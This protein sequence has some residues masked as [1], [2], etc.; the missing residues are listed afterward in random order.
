[1]AKANA[2]AVLE[3]RN[4]ATANDLRVTL[5]GLQLSQTAD[6]PFDFSHFVEAGFGLSLF[7]DN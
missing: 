7:P 2:L 6:H 3:S 1:M 5:R 4:T